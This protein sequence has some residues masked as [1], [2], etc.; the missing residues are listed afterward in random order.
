M[1]C[2]LILELLY[3]F[4]GNFNVPTN[5]CDFTIAVI[6]QSFHNGLGTVQNHFLVNIHL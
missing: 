2:E 5:L 4:F 3:I 6:I 1:L